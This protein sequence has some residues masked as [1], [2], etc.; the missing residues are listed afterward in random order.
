MH[1]NSHLVSSYTGFIRQCYIKCKLNAN[2]PGLLSALQPFSNPLTQLHLIIWLP[3]ETY[4][5]VSP[6]KLFLSPFQAAY[7]EIL[8][9]GN[10]RQTPP[11]QGTYLYTCLKEQMWDKFSAQKNLM[12]LAG[13][14]PGT[15]KSRVLS[16]TTRPQSPHNVR[17][18]KDP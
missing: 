11:Y 7:I 12:V 17:T 13:F 10:S 15:P 4:S 16:L 6:G 1:L 9:L 3:C 14:K 8:C 2:F 18:F 5:R